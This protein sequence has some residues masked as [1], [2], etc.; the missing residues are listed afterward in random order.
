[1]EHPD[2][3]GG[4][5]SCC[6]PFFVVVDFWKQVSGWCWH[7]FV[8]FI[9]IIIL[10]CWF[11][12]CV[13]L[14]FFPVCIFLQWILKM[15]KRVRIFYISASTV[16]AMPHLVKEIQS[17]SKKMPCKWYLSRLI[18]IIIIVIIINVFHVM[19]SVYMDWAIWLKSVTAKCAVCIAE[20]QFWAVHHQLLQ[21]EAAAD[22]HRTH[23]EGG[24]RG[25][26]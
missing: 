18:I 13:L 25:I 9:F 7:L 19:S 11:V 17:S 2:G 14:V 8:P 26:H 23:S 20:Q 24:A 16:S 5:F 1:M 4:Y 10:V 3:G 6:V 22:L 12:T 21:W 15:K